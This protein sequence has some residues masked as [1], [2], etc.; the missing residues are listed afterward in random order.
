STPRRLGLAARIVP[1]RVPDPPPTSTTVPLPEKLYASTARTDG[2]LVL[3]SG[4]V[5]HAAT[6]SYGPVI[7]L[8]EGYCGI[9]AY[10]DGMAVREKLTDRIL[11]LDDAL[12]ADLPALLGLL[13]A[14]VDD[15]DWEALD[16]PRRRARTLAALKRLVLR[17]SQEA[18]LLLV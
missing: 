6:P 17:Q 7:N 16:P 5:S 4:A 1:R 14:N 12:V 3:E 15:A 18:P 13:D 8:L 11:A 2:W 10:D 9:E